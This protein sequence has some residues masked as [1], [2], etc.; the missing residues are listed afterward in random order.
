MELALVRQ[1]DILK[2]KGDCI[3]FKWNLRMIRA[4]K[5]TWTGAK[6]MRILEEK[7]GIKI[8]PADISF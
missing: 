7:V 8:S 5:N 6:L 2:D 4:R 1:R 3:A